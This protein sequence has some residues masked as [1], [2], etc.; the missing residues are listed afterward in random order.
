MEWNEHLL[1]WNH[2]S[3]KVMDVRRVRIGKRK[4]CILTAC[5]PVLLSMSLKEKREYVLK[6]R[7]SRSAVLMFF[8]QARV[9]V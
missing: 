3:V 4:N 8:M 7:S 1:V 2:A 5:L 6:E 9:C